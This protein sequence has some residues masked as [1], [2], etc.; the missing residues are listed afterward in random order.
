VT[1]YN[2]LLR[3]V[4]KLNATYPIYLLRATYIFKVS[5]CAEFKGVHVISAPAGSYLY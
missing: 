1:L 5:I 4:I 3:K 2:I